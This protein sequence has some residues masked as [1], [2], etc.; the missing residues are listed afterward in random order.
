MIT[1][2]LPATVA[3][4]DWLPVTTAPKTMNRHGVVVDHLLGARLALFLG[5][6][7]EAGVQLDRVAADATELGVDV[8]DR[9][10]GGSGGRRLLTDAA[11]GIHP[12]D[13]DRVQLSSAAPS[14]PPVKAR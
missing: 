5:L 2:L 13:G 6:D 10:L 1:G 7:D 11:L 8:G 4:N 9:R 12:A 14:V 3:W